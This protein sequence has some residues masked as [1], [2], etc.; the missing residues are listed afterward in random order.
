MRYR[1][2]GG[3]EH[4]PPHD[5]DVV[6]P[7]E[8]VERGFDDAE[9]HA[10]PRRDVVAAQLPDEV[11]L[12][13][14]E[15]NHQVERQPRLLHRCWS[16]GVSEECGN[17]SLGWWHRQIPEGP[18]AAPNRRRAEMVTNDERPA[19]RGAQPAASTAPIGTRTP[20][21]PARPLIY[22]RF[23]VVSRALGRK[24]QGPSRK[25]S[26]P[27]LSTQASRGLVIA[28]KTCPAPLQ[29]EDEQNGG[30]GEKH[31]RGHGHGLP[32]L[33]AALGVSRAAKKRMNLITAAPSVTTYIAGNRQ[34]TRGN[35]SLTPS[36]WAR[37]SARLTPLVRD[38]SAW[39]RKA[40][41]M[42]VP[43]RSVWTSIDTSDRTSSTFVP[44]GEVLEGLEARLAGPDL[45]VDQAQLVG[46]GG[47]RDLQF[48]GR[49]EDRLVE[50]K[51]RL[52]A[53]DQQVEGVGQA[54]H[55]H[56][57][58]LFTFRESRSPEGGTP[59]TPAGLPGGDPA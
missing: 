26:R 20:R 6:L 38:T 31:E 21:S 25:P 37:S 2:G 51:P 11:E 45:G 57:A 56:L 13:Q 46:Q 12:L 9:P 54:V 58:A 35:T 59:R 44:V 28:A 5:L 32:P 19:P 43:N 10:E 41:A 53:H 8:H 52:D 47:V 33:K 30:D 15:L 49:L 24:P 27:R 22:P 48:L 3:A 34:N 42:L 50:T 14:R 36:F 55:D 1:K 7:L 40:C 23:S 29:V 17:V 4:G 16:G 18:P 39:T